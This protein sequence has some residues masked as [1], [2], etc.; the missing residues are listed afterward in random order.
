MRDMQFVVFK[1][2]KQSFCVDIDKVSCITEMTDISYLPHT[3]DYISGVVNLRGEIIPIIDLKYRFNIE[4]EARTNDARIIVIAFGD[5]NL[6]FI[7]DAVSE[8]INVSAENI[9]ETPALIAESNNY[10]TAIAK[11]EDKIA[12]VLDLE[13]VFNSDEKDMLIALK[14]E[15]E[16]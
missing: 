4:N 15:Q 6:G 12:V 9:A 10:I 8:V 14:T 13:N 1:L 5:D 7:V 11:I 2:G 3:A 16:G